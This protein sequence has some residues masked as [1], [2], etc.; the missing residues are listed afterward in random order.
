MHR[1]KPSLIRCSLSGSDIAAA[2]ICG[3]LPSH[4]FT[5]ILR[6]SCGHNAHWPFEQDR[7]LHA[8]MLCSYRVSVI[9]MCWSR[10][11]VQSPGSFHKLNPPTRSITTESVTM[12]N[13][14]LSAPRRFILAGGFALAVAAAPAVAALAGVDAFPAN[15]LACP[16]GAA[17]HRT[18]GR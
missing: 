1:T 16:G 4:S 6:N 8:A 5:K 17:A 3:A 12:A 15:P 13:P 9:S 14:V 10:P 2:I 11:S 7:M 18:P